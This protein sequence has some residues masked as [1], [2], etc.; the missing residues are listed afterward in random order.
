[1]LK[2]AIVRIV[3]CSTRSPWWVIALALLLSAVSAV[4]TARHFAIKTDI[5]ELISPD[6]P[7]SQRVRQFLDAFPQR[8]ILAVVDAPT[9]ELV[10]QATTRLA[11]A[12]EQKA[13][14][15]PAV[16]QPQSGAF[17]ERNGLLYLATEE[18]RRVTAGLSRADALLETL[19]AD[20][21]LRGT[22]DALSLGLTGVERKEVKLDDMARPMTMAADTVEAVLAGQPASFSWRVLASG[23]PAEPGD[24]RRFIE[25]QPKLDFGAL[26]P[27][28]VATEAIAQTAADLHLAA[29]YRARVR[30]TGLIPIDD[31][32]FATVKQNAGL[33]AAA[34]LLAVLAILW[35]AL[36]SAQIIFAVAVSITLGLAVSAAWGLFLVGA[37]NLISVAFFVLFV[38]LGID[39]GIQFSVRYRAERHDI[40]DLRTGSRSW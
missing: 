26:E 39:F 36:R 31:D 25:I 40:D 38:G 6:L 22:L 1:M 9:P 4:Y 11:Q 18:V 23:K 30:M 7:W 35:L 34:S 12:L 16:R 27:G 28:R 14:L 19:A 8:E 15:F 37:L 32:E 3:G 21:S 20:P 33:N 13:S 5:N 24:L 10:E 2:R 17:F 29:E